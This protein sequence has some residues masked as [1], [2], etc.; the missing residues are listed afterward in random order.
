MPKFN[1]KEVTQEE[2]EKLKEDAKQKGMKI[3][4]VSPGIYKTRLDG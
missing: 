2:L 3:E 4:E 1:E